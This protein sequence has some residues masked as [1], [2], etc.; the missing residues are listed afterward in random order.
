MEDGSFVPYTMHDGCS[1]CQCMLGADEELVPMWDLVKNHKK[2]NHMDDWTFCLEL[3][4]GHGIPKETARKHLEKMFLADFV[5]AG[6][7]RHYGNFGLIR[8][9]ETLQYT[10][11]AP[12]YD[13]G[14]CL[15][16]DKPWLERSEDYEYR[17]KPFGPDGMNPKD[18]LELF[19]HTRLDAIELDGF[20]EEARAI[21]A[22]NPIMPV[23]RLDAV[24]KGVERNIGYLKNH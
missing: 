21:L 6:S 12:V 7:D 13:S 18:Q 20:A 9:M 11:M 2:P 4:D 19:S 24:A 10:R 23:K 5:L 17:A 22:K 16:C 3:C 1:A 8:N 14:H 15:W